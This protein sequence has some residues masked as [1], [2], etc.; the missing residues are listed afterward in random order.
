MI[1]KLAFFAF[2]ISH[3]GFVYG[4]VWAL[5]IFGLIRK[6]GVDCIGIDRRNSFLPLFLGRF[7]LLY[8]K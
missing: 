1:P 3:F 6:L 4:M 2:R 7:F 5:M 8:Q